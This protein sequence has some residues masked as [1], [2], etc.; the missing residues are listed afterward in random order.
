MVVRY[1]P[2]YGCACVAS[3]QLGSATWSYVYNTNHI[4]EVGAQQIW[5]LRAPLTLLNIISHPHKIA[6]RG[7]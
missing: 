5:D 4:E 1:T 2:R 7:R 3:V 6:Y